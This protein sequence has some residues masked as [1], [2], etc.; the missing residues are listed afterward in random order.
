VSRRVVKLVAAVV[1]A[2]A[3]FL[4]S[5]LPA[6]AAD[7][8]TLTWVRHG[9]S[10]GNVAGAGIDT[11]VPGPELTVLGEQQAEAV[12]AQLLAAGSYDNIYVSDM[13][14]TQETAA[15]LAAAVGVTPVEVGGF[16]EIGAGI[17]EGSPIDSGLGRIGYFVV[18]L[19]WTLGLRSL[20]IPLG[21]NGNEFDARVDDSIATVI[22]NGDTDPLIFSHG[23]TIMIWTMMN[24]DNPDLGL[25]L[26][27]PLGNT[28]MVVVTGNPQDGWTL[29]SWDGIAVDANPSL[30]TKLFVNVRD[31]V[32]APQT[33]LYS[34]VQAIE[35]GDLTHIVN[36]VNDGVVNVVTAAVDFARDTVRDI[37]EA[38]VGALPNQTQS[39]APAAVV[40]TKTPTA[41]VAGE[42][43][44]AAE[45][46]DDSSVTAVAGKADVTSNGATDLTDG[47]KVEPGK[48]ASGSSRRG[49]SLHAVA[50][51]AGAQASSAAVG[52]AGTGAKR[53]TGS[54]RRGSAGS[55][56]AAA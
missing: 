31:L 25:M 18:P 46:S 40:G 6:W 37:T 38:I 14:R 24:V 35:T 50:E 55:Q 34:V 32:A 4:M 48:A 56:K 13:I 3:L 30:G 17:F 43:P 5:A 12:A 39:V 9:E 44:A 41:A 52:K 20:S 23:A 53:S 8:I 26:T 15:P 21:E 7:S 2:V 27:H 28:A 54:S 1:S 22:A 51:R 47:N 33:S 45:S 11:S 10:Y 19:A 16:R 42:T 29:D 49:G 36:A